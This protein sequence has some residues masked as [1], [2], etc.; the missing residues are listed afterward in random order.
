MSDSSNSR[1]KRLRLAWMRRF[2]VVSCLFPLHQKTSGGDARLHTIPFQHDPR[3]LRPAQHA[4]GM[5]PGETAADVHHR[6]RLRRTCRSRSGGCNGSARRSS[7]SAASESGRRGRGPP[8]SGRCVAPRPG[9]VVRRVAQAQAEDVRRD[10]STGRAAARTTAPRGRSTTIGS[11]RT[12]ICSQRVAEHRAC[13]RA[14]A[15]GGS[16]RTSYQASWLPRMAKAAR[17]QRSRPSTGTIQ[18]WCQSLSTTSPVSA[19]RSG[20]PSRRHASIT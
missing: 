9:D 10:S 15:G 11:P 19:T 17:F 3:H 20:T 7:R 6:R 12:S 16:A 2:F 14:A 4:Q 1:V 5:L 8:A 13:R 18:R